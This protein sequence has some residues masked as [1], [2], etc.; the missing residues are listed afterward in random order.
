MPEPSRRYCLIS[1][2]RDEAAFARRTLDS[3]CAQSVRPAKWVIVDDGSTDATPQILA[4]Y[5]AQFDFIEVVTRTDRGE[6]KVG[7]GV[8][9]AFYAGYETIDPAAFDYVCKLD[10]DLDLPAA[11]F[12]TLMQ[13]MEAQP[14]IGTC[15]GKAYYPAPGEG[16]FEKGFDAQL[17]SE[18]C[19]DEMSVG[20]I[21]FYRRACFEDIGGFVR[22]VMWDGI[23][24]HRCRMNGWIARSW[25][26]AALRFLHLRPMGSSH[27]GVLTGRMRHGFGQWFM[28]TGPAYMA[29]SAAFRM[30]RPPAVVGG[31][32][33]GWGYLRAMLAGEPR[34]DDPG[35]RRFLRR[36]QWAC[37]MKGKAA[38]TAAIDQANL[39]RGDPP[40]PPDA[41]E[42]ST[43][44]D[45]GADRGASTPPAGPR[46]ATIGGSP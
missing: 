17:V 4:E 3:V 26:D 23:D 6:R 24:C 15:S 41:A 19:G 30:T 18:A 13:R 25:D 44:E 34:Y 22:Q 37:L 39:Q 40:E 46:P 29:A 11:Y 16:T 27:K 45:H 35:F 9:D 2:T 36:Y 7:P 38:A 42:P 31:L 1:P 28:G 8:I 43:T 12:E 20:M 5:A 14:R 33:M 32:A 21:K 10:L